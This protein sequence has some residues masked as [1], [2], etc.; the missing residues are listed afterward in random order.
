MGISSENQWNSNNRKSKK[1]FDNYFLY[2]HVIGQWNNQ[3][4]NQSIWSLEFTEYVIHGKIFNLLIQW[5]SI[6]RTTVIFKACIKIK[7]VLFPNLQE[8]IYLV[9]ERNQYLLRV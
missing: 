3:S 4:I 9:Y 5:I 8:R 7:S 6:I 2:K 1:F